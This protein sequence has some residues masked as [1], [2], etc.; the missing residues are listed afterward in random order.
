ME[1]KLHIDPTLEEELVLRV[2]NE[3]DFATKIKE[4][5]SSYNEKDNIAVFSGE[6]VRLINFSEIECVTVVDRKTYVVT[7]DSAK[8]R[9]NST[10]SAVEEILPS[11]F[12]RINKSSLANEKYIKCFKTLFSG[13][14]DAVFKSGYTEY[15][16]RRCFAEIKRR[17][18]DEK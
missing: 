17:L 4:M 5:V 18:K 7:A 16:S 6:E 10:L 3:C 14:V 12:I 1:F 15:V 2:K 9:I 11:N 8:Y 13:A